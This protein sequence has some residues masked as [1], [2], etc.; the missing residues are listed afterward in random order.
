MLKRKNAA[1]RQKFRNIPTIVDGI[2]FDSK[3]EATHFRN[4]KLWQL[5]GDINSLTL[6]VRFPLVVEG[7]KIATYV[8]D[9][10]YRDK[11]GRHV[12]DVKSPVTAKLPVYRL[13]KKLMAAIYGINIEEWL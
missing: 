1:T 10:V 7:V 3:R 5:A 13:K 8:A 2:R 4:L 9:F 12:I 6:Q 11:T